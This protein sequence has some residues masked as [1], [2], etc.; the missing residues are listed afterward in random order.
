MEGRARPR[1]AALGPRAPGRSVAALFVGLALET[2]LAA[3]EDR[4]TRSSALPAETNFS[5][6]VSARLGPGPRRAITDAAHLLGDPVC[7]EIFFEFHDATGRPLQE[8]LDRTGEDAVGYLGWVRF[9]DGSGRRPCNAETILAFT[10]PGSRVVHLCARQF[11]RIQR[12]N[13]GLASRMIIH[14]MLHTL[15]LGENPPSSHEITSRISHRCRPAELFL[16]GR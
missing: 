9:A 14:E 13:P 8:N 4:R 11:D 15:G 12:R 3:E 10:S 2:L 1:P 7:R 16:T 6:A 5:S